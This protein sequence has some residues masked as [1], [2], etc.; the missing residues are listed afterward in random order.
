LLSLG[1]SYCPTKQVP[2]Q[3]E[4]HTELDLFERKVRLNHHFRKL[5]IEQGGSSSSSSSDEDSTSYKPYNS[6]GWTPRKGVNPN[7]ELFVNLVRDDVT[8]SRETYK[9]KNNLPKRLKDALQRLKKDRSIV[10]KP[11]DKG[12][13]TVV[14]GLDQYLDEAADQLSNDLHYRRTNI[15]H[16]NICASQISTYLQQCVKDNLLN[17]RIVASLTPRQPRTPCFYMLPKIHKEG[18]PGRPIISASSGPTDQISRFV[19]T[20]IK[21]LVP[22]IPSYVKDT[23]DFIRKLRNVESIPTTAYLCTIDVKALYTNIPH[24]QGIQ[25][26]ISALQQN[27]PELPI[28]VLEML[29]WFIL[30]NNY[31]EFNG[32]HFH[33]LQGTAMG[34]AMAPSYANLFMAE[35]ES[36]LLGRYHYKPHLW[37]RFID[38][39]FMIWLHSE[40]E[41]LN[42]IDWLNQQ[43]STI[44]FTSTHSMGQVNYLDLT[45][46]KTSNGTLK[47]KTFHKPT[48]A[49]TYLHYTSSHPKNQKNSIPYSQYLRLKRNSTEDED[50]K[51]STN[52]LTQAFL[53]RGYPQPILEDALSKTDQRDRN[54][55]L[56]S[57]SHKKTKSDKVIFVTT[58]NPRGQNI[59]SILAKHARILSKHPHTSHLKEDKFMV[60][61]RRP[62][63]LKDLLVHSRLTMTNLPP[64]MFRCGAPR[65]QICIHVD[66][67]SQFKNN[68]T[69]QLFR[70]QGHITCATKFVIYLIKCTKCQKQY[71]G[72]TTQTLRARAMQH[73]NDVNNKEP[74]RPVAVH[75]NQDDH[76]LGYFSIMGI[77]PAPRSVNHTLAMESAWI[78]LLESMQPWGINLAT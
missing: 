40:K 39:I 48:D 26:S 47:T 10:I 76:H 1:L 21:P 11:A 60:A 23:P 28:H 68:R 58:Y 17:P 63:N 51:R 34:T 49:S 72:Q 33:Q 54:S 15:D 2:T 52:Q 55:L 61:Y 18:I 62:K 53:D 77:C 29:M 19:D 6:S 46:Y 41:L 37:L 31:F 45:V 8:Q 44:K 3:V 64:G 20:Y 24:L 16:T 38:D 42:F 67:T 4:T 78:R 57:N 66:T 56:T 73:R 74:Y 22:L 50:F 70:T 36:N 69:N 12:G 14:W 9:T 5:R 7:L 43:H 32:L 25:A 65:C 27:P 30:R 35:L 71:V 13:A 59:K 75:F